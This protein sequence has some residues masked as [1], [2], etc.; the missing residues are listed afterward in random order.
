LKSF[1]RILYEHCARLLANVQKP[2]LLIERRVVMG[3][4][5]EA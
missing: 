2:F 5:A 3:I 1:K 4:C